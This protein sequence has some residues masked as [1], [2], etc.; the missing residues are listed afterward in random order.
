MVYMCVYVFVDTCAMTLHCL[1]AKHA[2]CGFMV[3]K[4]G[5]WS[6]K[7]VLGLDGWIG[8]QEPG[9]ASCMICKVY[10]HV[11]NV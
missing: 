6:G 1:G 3:E 11:C 9:T 10:A 7:P 2:V 4:L 8:Y 5:S